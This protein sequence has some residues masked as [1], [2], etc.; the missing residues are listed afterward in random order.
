MAKI[1][2]ERGQDF[3]TTVRSDQYIEL[4]PD[5]LGSK[6]EMFA[7]IVTLV[8]I[9]LEPPVGNT[10]T[11]MERLDDAVDGMPVRTRLLA[12]ANMSAA[13]VRL[14]GD[15]A[16]SGYYD[17]Y[18]TLSPSRKSPGES[19]YRAESDDSG[20]FESKASFWPVFEFRP[21]G[22]RG[23]SIV[24]D[25]GKVDVPGF[26]MNI[27]SSGG[28]WSRRPPTRAAVTAFRA[29]PFFYEGE[30]LITA[31]RDG[32]TAAR[33]ALTRAPMQIAKCAKIQAEL[34]GPDYN[35]MLGRT[36]LGRAKPFANREFE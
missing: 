14:E 32:Q 3:L 17:L 36:N 8:G 27:G 16:L 5:L 12:F 10:D 24:V 1:L 21:L 4:S 2:F 7:E 18:V 11:I 26:P 9:P 30:V 15:S 31:E 29:A 22:G 25:T 28:R 19:V 35:G 34:T 6:M 33:V 13:P 23:Q 20:Y